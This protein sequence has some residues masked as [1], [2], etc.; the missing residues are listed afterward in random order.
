MKKEEHEMITVE[1]IL[2][3]TT[4]YED[5]QKT[6]AF[7]VLKF[8]RSGKMEPMKLSDVLRVKLAGVMK[9]ILCP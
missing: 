7:P 5:D 1:I 2:D 8:Y 6:V 3:K 4:H 9:E